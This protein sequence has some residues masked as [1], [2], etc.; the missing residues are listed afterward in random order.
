MG[1]TPLFFLLLA[2]ELCLAEKTDCLFCNRLPRQGAQ[3][4]GATEESSVLGELDLLE[5]SVGDWCRSNGRGIV[6]QSF[7][8]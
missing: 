5:Q 8:T 2:R 6:N 1:I 3:G 7:E 4:Q